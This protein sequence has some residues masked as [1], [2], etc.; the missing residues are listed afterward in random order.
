ML[1][2]GGLKQRA[3]LAILLL[4]RGEV[5]AT[6]RMIDELW[7]ERPPATAVKALH[8]YVSNL[9]KALGQGVLVT[10]D[11]GY[12]LLVEP[13]QVDVDRF[14]ALLVCGREA[15][16]RAQPEVAREQ[17][18]AALALWRGDP[19]SDFAYNQFAQS[20]IARLNE[21][22]VAALEYRVEAELA[23]GKHATLV[24]ELEAQVR[25]HPTR[26]RFWGQLMV[27][28]YRSG[29]QA[30]ALERYRRARRLLIDEFAIEPGPQ[31]KAIEH[32]I[33]T[34]DP[35]LDD[36]AE[37]HP[38]MMPL[39]SAPETDA[40]SS[41]RAGQSSKT[42]NLGSRVRAAPLSQPY[43]FSQATN[44]WWKAH[45]R[46]IGTVAA[47]L[48]VAAV[49]V[50]VATSVGRADVNRGRGAIAAP[51]LE[52]VVSIS[53]AAASAVY[54]LHASAATAFACSTKPDDPAIQS[55]NDSTGHFTARGGRGPLITSKPRMPFIHRD[56]K[57]QRTGERAQPRRRHGPPLARLCRH[58]ADRA[59][60]G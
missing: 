6:D 22:R 50:A 35:A 59:D 47:V 17:F 40:E 38:N 26:E 42:P 34:Q 24:P 31:L 20:E 18:H 37:P 33:L 23:T 5:V 46:L 55:C 21:A 53:F 3:V 48:T 27:A 29:R 2:L 28:L 45:R 1:S 41:S 10:R 4:H 56:C 12:S 30:E 51:C 49:A 36:P 57:R 15:L 25:A 44:A 52:C 60:F 7:P 8:V 11:R 54:W 58:S 14:D 9:R 39:D 13:G 32:A 19:L 43:T 16:E